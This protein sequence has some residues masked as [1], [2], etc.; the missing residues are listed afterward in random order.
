MR[1]FISFLDLCGIFMELKRGIRL[2]EHIQTRHRTKGTVGKDVKGD[3]Q[4][5]QVFQ[6]QGEIMHSMFKPWALS[7]NFEGSVVNVGLGRQR[8]RLSLYIN[9]AP[10][11]GN[12]RRLRTHQSCDLGFAGPGRGGRQGLGLLVWTPAVS[13]GLQNLSHSFGG[14]SPP[15]HFHIGGPH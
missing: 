10:L 1:G 15:C 11:C 7:C 3:R 13:L 5:V 4:C 12:G 14:F 6:A 9:K 2:A 8:R